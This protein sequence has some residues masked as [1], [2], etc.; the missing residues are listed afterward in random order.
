MDEL[1]VRLRDRLPKAVAVGCSEIADDLADYSGEVLPAATPSRLAEFRGGRQAARRAMAALGVAE[2]AVPMAA[3][4]APIW[5]AGLVG[6]ISHCEGL[7]LALVARADRVG[8]LGLD[9]EPSRNLPMEIWQTV[10]RPEEL[11]SLQRVEPELQGKEALRYFVA[12]EAVYKAQYPISKRLF[13]FQAIRI[14]IENQR[15]IAEFLFGVPGFPSGTRLV[16]ELVEAT[17]F[18]AATVVLP[19]SDYPNA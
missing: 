6:S 18:I 4:R 1:A 7:C 19:G 11:R 2:A 9:V 13:D 8:G 5:P 14:M 12:K 16:G 15:F 3:D 10:L 17:G